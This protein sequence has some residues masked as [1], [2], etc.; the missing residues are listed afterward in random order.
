MNKQD[1]TKLK[2]FALRITLGKNKNA[3]QRLK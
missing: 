2:A 3:S 1:F